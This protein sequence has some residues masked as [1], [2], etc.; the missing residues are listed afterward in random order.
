MSCREY[1]H[2]IVLF[3]YEELS[4]QDK[5]ALQTHLGDCGACKQVFEEQ[6]DL[7]FALNEDT[8]SWDVPSD[9]L[10]E[11]RKALADE[12]DHLEHKRAWWRIPTFSVVLTPMR[13]LESGALIAMGLALGVYV[14]KQAPMSAP[15]SDV[16]SVIPRNATVSNLRIVDADA[17]TGQVEL[18]GEVVQ[19][20]RFAGTLDDDTVQRLTLS[21]LS[22]AESNPHSRLHAMEVL[23]RK[24]GDQS[25]K[26]V[27][28]YTL[29]HDGNPGVRTKALE[30]LVPYLGDQDV[31]TAFISVLQNDQVEGIRIEAID[32]LTRFSKDDTVAKTIQEV[33][34]DD[35]NPYLRIKGLQF[36]GTH[37]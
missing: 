35:S 29:M 22:G 13:L 1:Q 31:R 8:S 9:L 4:E 30:G 10:V 2:H 7:H 33:T 34:K 15:P 11:S 17:A 36:V 28:I 3:L 14:S 20:L 18:A 16:L 23:S 5:A 24:A 37:Q 26:D 27:L 6:K 12:L 25:V 21:A 19:P 32:A